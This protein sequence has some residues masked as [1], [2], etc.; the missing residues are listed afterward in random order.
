MKRIIDV[1][2]K[3]VCEGFV[4]NFTEE[5]RDILIRAI[6][7]STPYEERSQGD[8]ISR[9][10]LK[11]HITEIFETEEKID[12]KWAMG[13]KYSLKIIDNAPAVGDEILTKSKSDSAVDIDGFGVNGY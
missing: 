10:A 9:E 13:L 4:R 3:L 7:D 8:L 11:K 12:K 2:E 6:R 5:E 1:D